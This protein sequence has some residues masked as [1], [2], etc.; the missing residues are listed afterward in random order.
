MELAEKLNVS[1][2]AVSRWEVGVAVPSTDNLK[3]LGDLYGVSVDYLLND[4]LSEAAD[5]V[6]DPG[7]ADHRESIKL[8]TRNRVLLYLGIAVIV[9]GVLIA[10]IATRSHIQEDIKPIKN[11]ETIVED[12]YPTEFFSIK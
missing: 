12:S 7:V 11:L 5:I 1:R 10:V 3:I 2:Q 6:N 8:S 9:I 4:E